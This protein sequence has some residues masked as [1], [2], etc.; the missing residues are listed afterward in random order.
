M[1]VVQMYLL[2]AK[3]YKILGK[4]KNATACLVE[5]E[6]VKQN[7][8]NKY[9][10]DGGWFTFKSQTGQSAGIVLGIFND[11][12]KE[13]AVENLVSIIK[14]K[15]DHLAV[16]INGSKY[17]YTALCEN[18]YADLAYKMITNPTWPSYA[19]I[20]NKGGTSLWEIFM[21]FKEVPNQY[22]RVDGQNR[23]VS[24]NHHFYGSV[25]AFFYKRLA[26]LNV[27]SPKEI[28]IA[29]YTVSGL[30]FAKASFDNGKHSVKTRWERFDGKVKITVENNGF[31]GYINY[32]GQSLKLKNGINILTV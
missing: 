7:I 28:E 3:L 16:G 14:E 5:A 17:I 32:K 12:E 27:K 1:L 21:N 19:D 25:S 6:R 2:T 24:L 9:I 26:G 13:K 11:E 18:G 29:P 4:K 31:K 30:T 23:K 15:G 8:R 10:A 22:E 20:V